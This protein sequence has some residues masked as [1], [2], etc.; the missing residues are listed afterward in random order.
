VH[1]I[2]LLPFPVHLQSKKGYQYFES[3]HQVMK[4]AW[5]CASLYS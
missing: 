3:K 2:I 5:W 1:V 4:E